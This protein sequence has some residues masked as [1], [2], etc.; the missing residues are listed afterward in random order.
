MTTED[1]G[2]ATRADWVDRR[3][4]DAILRGELQPG[5]KLVATTLSDRWA[6]SATPLREAFQRLAGQGLVDLEPHRGARV[7]QVSAADAEEIYELRRLLDPMALR[8]SLARSDADHRAEIRA[9]FDEM[10]RA[11]RTAPD[12]VTVAE[13]HRDFHRA[14]LARCPSQWLLRLTSLLADH[15]LRYQ[16]LSAA[17][18]PGRG[19]ARDAHA[20]HEALLAAALAGDADA[21]AGA[22]EEHL[23]HTVDTVREARRAGR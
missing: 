7:A 20:E 17:L 1:G 9:A 5:E 16:V 14:L 21:A 6:V 12:V 8:Q 11:G 3:L 13:A 4:K 18:G 10:E 23:R 19:P 15:S 2:P 22:L